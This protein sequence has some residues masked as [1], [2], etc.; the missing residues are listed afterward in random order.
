MSYKKFPNY[1]ITWTDK[2]FH[3]SAFDMPVKF[4]SKKVINYLARFKKAGKI[5]LLRGINKYNK[6]NCAGVYSWTYDKKVALRYAKELEGKVLEKTFLP[7]Q[8]ILDTTILN[9]QERVSLGYD[10]SVDDKEV[11][12]INKII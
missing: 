1:V 7:E 5:K 2:Y 6:D 10:Y 8:I 3:Q 4:P 11:L 12:I 9:Q